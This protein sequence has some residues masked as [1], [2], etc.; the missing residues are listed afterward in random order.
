[1]EN[2]QFGSSRDGTF[3]QENPEEI[4]WVAI[5]AAKL[6]RRKTPDSPACP[7]LTH[8]FSCLQLQRCPLKNN[9][10]SYPQRQRVLGLFGTIWPL[11]P[12]AAV[13]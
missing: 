6:G 4:S 13:V 11:D 2:V 3:R 7:I 12:D 1:V 10:N 8:P 9:S 5:R